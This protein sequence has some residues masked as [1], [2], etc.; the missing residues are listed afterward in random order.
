M[1][2]IQDVIKFIDINVNDV[3]NSTYKYLI[4]N[5]VVYHDNNLREHLISINDAEEDLMEN[6]FI[7]EFSYNEDIIRK[8]VIELQELAVKHE[9]AY[10]RFIKP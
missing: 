10:I 7:K 9:A 1:I 5:F 3:N 6:E 2:T 4:N 8:E